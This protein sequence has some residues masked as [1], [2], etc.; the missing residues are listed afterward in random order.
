M[1]ALQLMLSST[2]LTSPVQVQAP[3]TRL[4]TLKQ[5]LVLAAERNLKLA[6]AQADVEAA[7][8]VRRTTRAVVLPLLTVNGSLTRNSN[9]VSFGP[10]DDVRTI[11]P[12][13]NWNFQVNVS[14]PIFAG[15]RDLKAYRQS[16]LNVDFAREGVRLAEDD[17]LLDVSSQF[18]LGLEAEA[19]LAVEQL[20]LELA[21]RRRQ[22]ASDLFEAGETTRVDVL[23]ADADIK[24]AER[25]VVEAR[26]GREVAVSNLRLALAIDE[27]VALVEPTDERRAVPELPSEQVLVSRALAARAE[28]RQAEHML[29]IA[30]LEVEKQRGA[31]FPVLTADA[32]FIKQK[33][34]FPSSSYGFAALRVSVPIYQGGEVSA[35]VNLAQKRQE[36]ATLALEEVQRRVREDVR[37][38]LFD[39]DATRTNLALAQ[40]QLRSSEA[41][42][43]QTSELY[44]SQELTS[45]DLQVS[46]AALAEARRAVATGR[47]LV[48]AAQIQA[49]YAAG[50]LSDVAL[51]EESTP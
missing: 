49:W 20:N 46:E 8:A 21:N 23:R 48:Y 17:V 50:V 36:Q 45:L 5:A 37:I 24:A 6:S 22:Q 39:L 15:L 47:L 35:Q 11:L 28:V 41:E 13:V 38:A 9:E 51:N 43:E 31:Y 4:L 32:A 10:P 19:L 42:Y 2:L 29:E 7:D 30:K 1:L 25:R 16:K 44:T 40:E 3:D 12:L 18:L 27:D 14:Q 34:T 33:T 26:R